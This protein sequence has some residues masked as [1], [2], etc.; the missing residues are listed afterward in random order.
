MFFEK[1]YK[2]SIKEISY[3]WNVGKLSARTAT[4]LRDEPRSIV[5]FS[6]DV[7]HDSQSYKGILNYEETKHH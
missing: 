4:S 6:D 1:T 2:F 3:L 5:I 7:V